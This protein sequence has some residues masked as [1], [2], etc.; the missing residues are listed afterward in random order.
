ML[1]TC[2]ETILG[3]ELRFEYSAAMVSA[4]KA[5]VPANNRRWDPD[6]KVWT[7]TSRYYLDAVL[8]YARTIGYT[9]EDGT[10][11]PP[12]PR[13][14]PTSSW[15][16]QL[17]TACPADLQKRVVRALARV[18]HPDLGGDGRLMQELNDADARTRKAS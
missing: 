7:V 1:L 8:S 15:A 14:A 12:R 10:T 9:V 16:E 13:A 6:L 18:L 3:W 4:V 5:L 11:A 2:K 17:L